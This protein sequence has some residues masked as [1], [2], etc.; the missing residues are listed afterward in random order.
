[1]KYKNNPT[2]S[3]F[4]QI[5]AYGFNNFVEATET[6]LKV[7]DP[8]SAEY[9]ILEYLLTSAVGQE[10]AKNWATINR[11]LKARNIKM[12]KNRWQTD[13]LQRSRRSRHYVGSSHAGYF[14]FGKQSD[15]EATVK[16]YLQRIAKEEEHLRSLIFA[17]S[18][19]NFPAPQIDSP[20]EEQ[21]DP[22]GPDTQEPS[23]ESS[24][25]I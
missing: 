20:K 11:H 18:K 15:V 8:E 2:Q 1:M 9:V 10:N 3:I 6:Y 5:Q 21:S 19:A 7:L 13:Y 12:T 25:E 17:A 14:I 24:H 4:R 22:I 23:S 16:F